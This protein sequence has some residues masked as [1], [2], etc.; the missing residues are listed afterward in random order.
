MQTKT[1]HGMDVTCLAGA[2][3]LVQRAHAILL[4]ILLQLCPPPPRQAL[5]THEDDA[6][7]EMFERALALLPQARVH[8]AG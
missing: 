7:F 3:G 4:A 6:S 1:V 2:H 8:T 5:G